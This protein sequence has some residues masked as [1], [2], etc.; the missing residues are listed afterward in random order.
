MTC[1][2]KGAFNKDSHNPN[3]RAAQ[4]YSITEDLA[5]TP[6]AMSTLESFHSCPSQMKALLSALGVVENTNLG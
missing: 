4:N 2:P 5:Q 3:P 1:I 6:C